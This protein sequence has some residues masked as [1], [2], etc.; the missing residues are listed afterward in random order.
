MLLKLVKQIIPALYFLIHG[1][2]HVRVS[3]RVA[4]LLYG[5]EFNYVCLCKNGRNSGRFHGVFK[6][7]D[8]TCDFIWT[9]SMLRVLAEVP[10]TQR[11]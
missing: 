6:V 11:W 1:F 3:V 7:I 8:K 5:K 9:K 4:S 10:L 2:C